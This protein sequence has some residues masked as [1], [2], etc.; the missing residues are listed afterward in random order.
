ML[1]KLCDLYALW[2]IERDRGWF[3]EH[4]RLS[5]T[6]SKAVLKTVNP[7]LADLRA[8]AGGLVDAFGIPEQQLDWHA[9]GR[10]SAA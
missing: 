3:Q 4:G 2:H 10:S 6:R 7:L 1:D 8:H 9:C 5:S